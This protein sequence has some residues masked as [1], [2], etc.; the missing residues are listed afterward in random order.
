MGLRLRTEYKNVP[1]YAVSMLQTSAGKR[2][3]KRTH[4]TSILRR[5][6]VSALTGA[7]WNAAKLDGKT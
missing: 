1:L 7:T 5:I 6:I 4:K 3:V 2:I